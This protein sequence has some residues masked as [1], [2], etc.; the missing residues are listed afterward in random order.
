MSAIPD[1]ARWLL[2]SDVDDTLTGDDRA[3]RT[4][5]EAL[6][7]A[8]TVRLALN[9]SRPIASVAKTIAQLTV[10]VEPDA[11]V[12]A[13]GTEIEVEGMPR[14]RWQ[15]RFAGWDRH[16]I[17][18][19]MARLGWP[20]H[21]DE[22]QTPF[23]A[24]FAVPEEAW[25]EAERRIGATG[26]AARFVRSAPDDFDVIPVTAG[27]EAPIRYLAEQLGIDPGAVVAAG[28]GAN[29]ATLLLAAPRAI[30]V[31]NATPQLR[32]AIGGGRVYVA[33]APHAAGILEGLL[34]TGILQGGAGR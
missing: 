32:H 16:P 2:I 18:Q 34:A 15:E 29:D 22:L 9:S 21:A 6:A 20:G 25:T 8:G 26:V 13:L 3:L 30:A 23:K 10:T 7:D 33:A 14:H 19:V 12:G 17:D 4:L 27:K 28:D 1:R 5:I 24:S 31:A 11:M